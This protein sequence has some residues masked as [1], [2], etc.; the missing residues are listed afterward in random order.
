[1]GRVPFGHDERGK[2][3][4]KTVYGATR[5]EVASELNKLLGRA[6]AGELLV[7]STPAVK[8]HL[9][10]WFS[11][12]KDDWA[13][14]TQRVYRCAIDEWVVP[15]L[16]SVSLERLKPTRIQAWINLATKNG[17]CAKVVLAHTVLH[18]A[19]AFAMRQRLITYNPA[20]LVKVPRPTRKP[21]VTLTNQQAQTFL[22]TALAH[23]LGAM[24]VIAL[25]MGLRISECCG[26]SWDDQNADARTLDIHQQLLSIDKVLT[27]SPLKTMNSKRLLSLPQVALDALK[28]HRTRQ[29]E[30]R[31][32]A[33]AQWN[34]SH[35]LMFTTESGRPM[36]QSSVR[37]ELLCVLAAAG[38]PRIK[39]HGLRHTCA[40]L[41]LQNGT[42]LFD[43]SRMFGHGSIE[44]TA[45]I[46][47]HWVPEI[48]AAATTR[49]DGLLKASSGA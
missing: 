25:S 19:L 41:L 35:N 17:A 42:P 37:V 32:R 23:R 15:A 28:V 21:I 20:A 8:A 34:N 31:M 27:L 18:S 38:V 40:R 4:R 12:H 45:D 22:D 46:Y 14:G 6:E 10:T 7:T 49:M 47:G 48:A 16:G 9:E 39:F 43:V 26:L 36:N 44:I 5:A 11:T 33:G 2:R 1:M 29:L 30:E 3:L 24:F 13:A